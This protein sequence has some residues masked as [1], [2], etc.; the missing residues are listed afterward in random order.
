MPTPVLQYAKADVVSLKDHPHFNENWVKDLIIH[1]PSLLGL[2]ELE[3]RAVEKTQ[4]RAGRLDLLLHDSDQ[5]IRYEVELM[6]GEVDPSHI[7]RTLEYWD[8]ERKRYPQ[9]EHRAVLVA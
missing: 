5:G 4:P 6:L 9:F 3:V 1:T 7:I 8:I 2:G